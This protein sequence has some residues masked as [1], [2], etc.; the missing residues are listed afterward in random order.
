MRWDDAGD[1]RADGER[2]DGGGED[3]RVPSFDLVELRGDE[4]RAADRCWYADQQSDE[5]LQEGSAED[6]TDDACAI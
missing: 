3:D 5:D 4:A 1:E 6:E 2:D